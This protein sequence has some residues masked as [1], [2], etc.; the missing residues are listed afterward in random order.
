MWNKNKDILIVVDGGVIQDI[1]FP[2]GC[3][4]KIIVRD[5]DIE[6]T[7]EDAL[8]LNEDGEECLESEYDPSFS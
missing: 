6:G 8:S 7:E 5:Y 4:T 2:P 1:I 3:T